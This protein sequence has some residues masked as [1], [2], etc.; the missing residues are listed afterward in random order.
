MIQSS[1]ERGRDFISNGRLFADEIDA[2]A[3]THD[4]FEI[5]NDSR[6]LNV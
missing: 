2:R 1:R 5:E 6:L 4:G 3:S